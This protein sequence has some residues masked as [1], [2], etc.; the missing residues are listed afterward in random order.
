MGFGSTLGH[1][2][3]LGTQKILLTGIADLCFQINVMILA[4]IT[5]A[6]MFTPMHYVSGTRER[7]ADEGPWTETCCRN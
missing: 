4:I 7:T 1:K 6:S 5:H 2:F 3:Y